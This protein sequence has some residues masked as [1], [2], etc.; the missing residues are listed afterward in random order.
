MDTNKLQKILLDVLKNTPGIKK[1]HPYDLVG[2][3]VE[4]SDPEVWKD[5]ILAEKTAKGWDLKVAITI[6]RG[7]QAKSLV[8]NVFKQLNFLLKNTQEKI[9]QLNIL[10]KGVHDE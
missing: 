4:D 1:I 8:N 6:L 10:I 9:F 7:I 5:L 2:V 3:N